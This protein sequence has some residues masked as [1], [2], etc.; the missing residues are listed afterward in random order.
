[1]VSGIGRTGKPDNHAR[2]GMD[3][4]QRFLSALAKP[5]WLAGL[6]FFGLCQSVVSQYRL[7]LRLSAGSKVECDASLTEF[8][9]AGCELC[10]GLREF[11]NSYFAEEIAIQSLVGSQLLTKRFVVLIL[12]TYILRLFVSQLS[13]LGNDAKALFADRAFAFTRFTK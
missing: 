13:A 1:M 8:N 11:V 6:H 12:A 7:G 3:S 4:G 2:L 10:S 9:Q 5:D